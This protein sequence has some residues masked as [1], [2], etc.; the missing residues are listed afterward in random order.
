M[1]AN[2]LLCGQQVSSDEMHKNSAQGLKDIFHLDCVLSDQ[3]V[4]YVRLQCLAWSSINSLPFQRSVQFLAMDISY[5]CFLFYS[6]VK[7]KPLN[8]L[9]YVY[10]IANNQYGK[11]VSTVREFKLNMQN[12]PDRLK[13]PYL[14]SL[15]TL[16]KETNIS[17]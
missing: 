3:P 5:P 15:S 4:K 7:G 2:V 12:I 11:Q 8:N 6:L 16:C 13:I 17:K 9:L 10:L 14:Q 1:Q